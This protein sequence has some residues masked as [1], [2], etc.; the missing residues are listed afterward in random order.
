MEGWGPGRLGQS[1]DKPNFPLPT[2]MTRRPGRRCPGGKPLESAGLEKLERANQEAGR[3]WAAVWPY[4][5]V[6][7]LL[8][9]D[10]QRP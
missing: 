4:I 1:H 6:E 8:P 9:T 7:T 10:S 3:D 5:G 2:L